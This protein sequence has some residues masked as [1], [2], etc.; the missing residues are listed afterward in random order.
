MITKQ[1]GLSWPGLKFCYQIFPAPEGCLYL[2]MAKKERE[3]LP[4]IEDKLLVCDGT[5]Y[6]KDLAEIEKEYLIVEKHISSQLAQ[7]PNPN[8]HPQLTPNTPQFVNTLVITAVL[9][10]KKYK[11]E[12]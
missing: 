2:G 4:E 5:T 1:T 9:E 10:C 3:T 6:R 11:E 12:K 8:Y 7:V